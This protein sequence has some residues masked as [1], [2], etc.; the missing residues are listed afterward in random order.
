MYKEKEIILV[1]NKEYEIISFLGKGKGGYSFLVRNESSFYV[2]KKIHHEPC[3]FYS[4]SNKIESEERDYYRLKNINLRMSE[5]IDIDKENEI[6]IKQYIKGKTILDLLLE[7]V[8]INK[9]MIQL[10]NFL[11]SLYQNS[12]NIDY[13][14]SNF[15]VND[16]DDLIYYIDF[17]CNN[18]MEKWDFINW[19]KSTWNKDYIL[20]ERGLIK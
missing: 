3:S 4:F 20:R 9:Y 5:L 14:P 12:I 8:D 17:E 13:H 11:P 2:L 19:G 7:D 18:Y 6:I 10:E 15:V 16:D 1:N